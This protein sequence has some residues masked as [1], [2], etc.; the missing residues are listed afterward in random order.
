MEGP[1]G[2]CLYASFTSRICRGFYG[3]GGIDDEWEKAVRSKGKPTLG[4]Q[5]LEGEE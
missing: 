1:E 4:V 3:E 2:L 5:V